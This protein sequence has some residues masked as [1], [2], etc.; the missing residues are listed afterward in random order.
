MLN[1]VRKTYSGAINGWIWYHQQEMVQVQ[2]NPTASWIPPTLP[3]IGASLFSFFSSLQQQ[4]SL[5]I[6]SDQTWNKNRS[7]ICPKH[8]KSEILCMSCHIHVYNIYIYMH[9][10]RQRLFNYLTKACTENNAKLLRCTR[11]RRCSH[12]CP[13]ESLICEL[14]G[15][16]HV[17][18]NVEENGNGQNHIRQN[19]IRCPPQNKCF[20]A[21]NVVHDPSWPI[22]K[23]R[24][25]HMDHHPKEH[26]HRGWMEKACSLHKTCTLGSMSAC[27]H[28]CM[29]ACLYRCMPALYLSTDLPIY[30]FVMS[31]CHYLPK[32]IHLSPDLSAIYAH[33]WDHLYLEAAVGW[34]RIPPRGPLWWHGP[35]L[36]PI[37]T[38]CEVPTTFSI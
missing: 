19:H 4:V 33:A 7:P 14:S 27:L 22:A 24:N 32:S 3:A 8:G 6:H 28:G 16:E 5:Y 12:W 9:I 34:T 26:F 29:V 35:T 25:K 13:K 15:G 31:I 38:H 11:A 30:V 2:M 36:M 21:K 18:D 10:E 1:D 17:K 20:S 23:P 37:P